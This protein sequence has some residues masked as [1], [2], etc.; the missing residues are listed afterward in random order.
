MGIFDWLKKI[1]NIEND[2][3]LNE[4]YHN[5]GREELKER[6]HRNDGKIHGVYKRYYKSGKLQSEIFHEYGT[7][8]G[9]TKGWY[10]SGEKKWEGEMN[11]KVFGEPIGKYVF[12]HP[13]GKVKK[14]TIHSDDGFPES[15]QCWDENGNE[16]DCSSELKKY[17][18]T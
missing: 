5:N 12:Y 18:E 11:K 4:I 17:Q 7:F 8:H 6:F 10:E 1:K 9:S 3:G 13:N 15:Q 16:I 2:N 14:Q